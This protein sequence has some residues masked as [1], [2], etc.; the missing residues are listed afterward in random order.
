MH[1]ESPA[2]GTSSFR[3]NNMVGEARK[4]GQEQVKAFDALGLSVRKLE[5]LSPEDQ[6]YAI[7]DAL[8]QVKNQFEQ[9]ELG[10][11][12]FG[13]GFAAL[14]PVIKESNGNLREHVDHLKQMG[15]ALGPETIKRIDEFGNHFG[16]PNAG[17]VHAANNNG[18]QMPPPLV[19]TAKT[20][21]K[22]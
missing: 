8:A 13:R 12:I 4:G 9:T 3:M 17:V 11:S 10:R 7:T 20:F 21:F 14:I 15:D 1:G 6:F 19:S 22:L 18:Q 2:E 5:Q 16:S